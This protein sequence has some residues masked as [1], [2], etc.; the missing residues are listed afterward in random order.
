MKPDARYPSDVHVKLKGL[1]H[2]EKSQGVG[3]GIAVCT[4]L[5]AVDLRRQPTHN[6]GEQSSSRISAVH[7]SK[8]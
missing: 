5:V 8:V 2:G 3:I 6:F 7:F 4:D 1:K